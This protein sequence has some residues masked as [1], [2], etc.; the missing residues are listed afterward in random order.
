MSEELDFIDIEEGGQPPSADSEKRHER[1][2]RREKQ[3]KQAR[4]FIRALIKLVVVAGGVALICLFVLCPY[5]VHGNRMFPKLR[6]GDCA[7]VLKVGVFQ[8]GDVVTYEKDGIRY[9]SRIV[10]TAGDIVSIGSDGFR[11]NGLVQSEEIFYET[12]SEKELEV[13]VGGD[14]VFLLNDYRSDQTDSRRF[15]SVQISEIDGKVIFLFRWRGI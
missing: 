12:A 1:R 13:T 14:E 11:V 10:G 6:D 15:G 9:F 2:R 4:S 5:A 7:V 8:K 3:N